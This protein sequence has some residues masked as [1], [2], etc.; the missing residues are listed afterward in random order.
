[1]E[2][3]FDNTRHLRYWQRCLRTLL[4]H[5]YTSND[6]TRM[7]LG[8]FTVAAIDLLSPS[9]SPSFLSPTEKRNLRGWVLACQHPS[10]GFAGSPTH[11]LPNSAY[12]G[13][14]FVT[15]QPAVGAHSTA[16]IA[17]TLFALQLLAL[18]SD[19]TEGDADGREHRPLLVSTARQLCVGLHCCSG[20]TAV[21][22]KFSPRLSITEYQVVTEH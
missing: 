7:T 21:L 14:D 15:G 3:S 20:R 19:N 5:Q 1:M 11:V 22:G 6:S 4:P 2:P 9:G 17:A 16:N 12:D 10:G 18:L 8:C 13:F